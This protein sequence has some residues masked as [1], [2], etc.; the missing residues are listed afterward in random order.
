M[1]HQPNRILPALLLAA[2]PFAPLFAAG[3]AHGGPF[4][5][6]GG[7]DGPYF[8]DERMERRAEHQAERLTRALDLTSE[9]QATL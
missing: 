2:L 5:G 7:G 4:A 1:N 6:H 9:Q 8:D 3:G